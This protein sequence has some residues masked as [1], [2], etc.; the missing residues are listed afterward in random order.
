VDAAVHGRGVGRALVAGLIVDA[1]E[2]G[3]E[4]LT[5]DA[6]GDNAHA[7]RLYRSLGFIE[8]GRLPDFV[9]VGERRYD[10]VFCMPDLRRQ[11]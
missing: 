10:K 4:V 8:Y 2:A 11:G 5:L 6:R 9:A 1:R 3:I 7:L